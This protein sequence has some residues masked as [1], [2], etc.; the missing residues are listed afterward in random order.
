[1]LKKFLKF[2]LFLAV[3]FAVAVGLTAIYLPPEQGLIPEVT[4]VFQPEAAAFGEKDQLY[5]LL[6]GLDYNYDNKAQR[7]TKGA[8]SDT[9]L[10]MRVE[11]RGRHLS[12]LSVPR[13]LLVPIGKDGV[14]GYDKINS[15]FA[16]GGVDLTRETVEQLLGL[17]IDHHIIVKSSVVEELV[18]GLGGVKVDVEI[19]MDYDDTWAGLHIHLKKGEQTLTGDQA[20]GYLRFRGDWD[21]DLGRIRRQQQFLEALLKQLKASENWKRYP[22]LAATVAENMITDLKVEQMVGL[23][24]IYKTFPLSRLRKGRVDVADHEENG[25]S[26]LVPLPE[27]METTLGYVFPE[28]P[29]ASLAKVSVVVEDYRR[30]RRGHRKMRDEFRDS[31]FGKVEIKG[32][33]PKQP[34]QTEIIMN[35]EHAV[36]K[37]ALEYLFPDVPIRVKKSHE[38]TTILVRLY[39]PA[40][41]G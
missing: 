40:D 4:A 34:G 17:K 13:D 10:L 24:Q 30:V 2:T 22:A 14:H 3:L 8:R 41:I 21:G 26:Y 37:A 25:I 23:A 39:S 6:L 19:D 1:M 31:G 11:P 9:I 18:D 33:R 27:A 12:M 29:P 16:N 7:H 32:I 20:V 15:A 5:I 28:L 35:G 38:E 36:A